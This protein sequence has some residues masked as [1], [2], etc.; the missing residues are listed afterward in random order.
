MQQSIAALSGAGNHDLS[1]SMRLNSIRSLFMTFNSTTQT[2][3]RSFD[4]A[5]PWSTQGHSMSGFYAGGTCQ[6]SIDSINYPQRAL[7][8]FRNFAGIRAELAQAVCSAQHTSEA[9]NM[10]LPTSE[11]NVVTDITEPS[12]VTVP[13]TFILGT[14]TERVTGVADRSL[15]G[16][17]SKN[18]NILCRLTFN[19]ATTAM[20]ATLWAIADMILIVDPV[21]KQ[22]TFNT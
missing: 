12:A 15:N 20:S 5:D 3:N 13:K 4:F 11:Y 8:S 16:I 10:S 17:S 18:A 7:D 22:L 2:T 1:Y 14:S 21:S 9:Y 19:A 6:F